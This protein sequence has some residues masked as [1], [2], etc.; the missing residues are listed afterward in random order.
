M[1][2]HM[3]P[4]GPVPFTPEEEAEWDARE[5][6][7]ALDANNRAWEAVR[8]QRNALLAASDWTDTFSAP[9]RLGQETYEAW[10]TYRQALRDITAQD[11]PNNVTWPTAPSEGA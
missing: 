3:T 2:H 6:Q 1:R 10:Q 8:T 11:D 4:D 9:T 7:Y 5:A